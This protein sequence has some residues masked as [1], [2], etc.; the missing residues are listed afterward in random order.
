MIGDW[1]KYTNSTNCQVRGIRDDGVVKLYEKH[2][3]R[4]I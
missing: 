1:V 2:R 3:K 4:R